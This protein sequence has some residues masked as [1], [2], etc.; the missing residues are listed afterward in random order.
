MARGQRALH[1]HL[2]AIAPLVTMAELAQANGDDLYGYDH[3]RLKLLVSVSVSGL[4]DNHYLPGKIRRRA[5]HSK[6]RRSLALRHFLARA[7]RAPL[8]QPRI[9]ALLHGVPAAPDRYLGGL[10]PP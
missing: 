6:R 4:N 8:P 7:L 5:G 1:Y 2:F 9:T 3:S 10:P